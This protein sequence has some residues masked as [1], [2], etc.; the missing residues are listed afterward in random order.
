MQESI[1]A[2]MQKAKMQIALN[3]RAG[4]PNGTDVF[5]AERG[6]V[7]CIDVIEV[8]HYAGEH[9][10]LKLS[11]MTE[12]PVSIHAKRP[13]AKCQDREC[14]GNNAQDKKKKSG[15]LP[16]RQLVT[17]SLSHCQK[18]LLHWVHG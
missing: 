3:R 9:N 1:H 10:T 2:K 8:I 13:S 4:L 5:D 11:R 17:L 15:N 12:M 14:L 7:Q 18:I 16:E 6:L